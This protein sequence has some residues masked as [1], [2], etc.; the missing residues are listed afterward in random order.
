MSCWTWLTGH[1]VLWWNTLCCCCWWC[2]WWTTCPYTVCSSFSS[3]PPV[4]TLDLFIQ[5]GVM[6]T[7]QNWPWCHCCAGFQTESTFLLACSNLT[8]TFRSPSWPWRC[9]LAS[10][11]K[12][13]TATRWTVN[14]EVHQDFI[15]RAE[16][17]L[18]DWIVSTKH[19]YWW[20]CCWEWDLF[21]SNMSDL[22]GYPVLIAALSPDTLGSSSDWEA[23]AGGWRS[24]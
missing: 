21:L 10:L 15:W 7:S 22:K 11:S 8:G 24:C 16:V 2:L 4:S 17:L 18:K 23:T 3:F 12:W 1:P 19:Q 5:H 14:P 6:S 13:R 9:S 20:S